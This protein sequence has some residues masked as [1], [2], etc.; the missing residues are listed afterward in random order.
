MI[1][2]RAETARRVACLS[3]VAC[4]AFIA[5][6][7]ASSIASEPVAGLGT[8]PS[9]AAAVEGRNRVD[10]E[11]DPLTVVDADSSGVLTVEQGGLGPALWQGTD[12]ALVD[13]LLPRLP[14]A[15]GSPAMRD[16]MRRLLLSAAAVPAGEAVPGRL[17]ALRANALLAMGDFGGVEALL[18]ATAM[19]AA[20][21]E[22]ARIRID[23]RLL[24]G[25][26]AGACAVAG[27]R[28]SEDAS[29]LWQKVLIFCQS[30]AGDHDKAG[31]G[32]ALLTEMG[33]RDP[34]FASLVAAL[35]GDEARIDALPAPTPLSLAM[36]RAAKVGLPEDVAATDDLAVLR[37]I[38]VSPNAPFAVR[39]AAA[40]RAQAG[41]ALDASVLRQLYEAVD[42]SAV[43]R[44]HSR[45]GDGDDPAV[46]R[47]M[48]YRAAAAAPT[49]QARGEA[50]ARALRTGRAQGRHA[51]TAFVYLPLLRET[52]PSPETVDLAGEAIPALLV[53][54]EPQAAER[55]LASLSAAADDDRR[56][57]AQRVAVMPLARLAWAAEWEGW[58]PADF[59]AWWSSIRDGDGAVRRATRMFTLLEA[60]GVE[61]P[62][63]LWEPLLLA[64][65]AEARAV[66]PAPALL[67]RL[68]RS[69]AAGR[70]GETILLSLL[71]LGSDGP[72]AADPLT[73]DS[74]MSSLTTVGFEREARA[75]AIE[76]A[77]AMQ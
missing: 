27:E 6:A 9:A 17:A 64:G 63:S 20:E 75:I 32:V 46:G 62:P 70:V 67:H 68:A 22:L 40:D 35:A 13:A 51:A 56:A 45:S 53:V 23:A 44:G 50:I 3:L 34:V 77:A 41:G 16:L 47:A 74:V 28:F 4:L 60:T 65:S 29:V 66:V 55:W 12:R 11:V 61:V 38:A 73:L 43:A 76:S 59:A 39:L 37:A 15:A 72:A 69:A 52:A 25:D 8:R 57:A 14:V 48:L 49:P 10:I 24:A 19:R 58:D 2:S 71:A 42:E 54:G 18:A 5:M 30:M 26:H 7:Q 36:A 31:L 21:P 1:A 33:E